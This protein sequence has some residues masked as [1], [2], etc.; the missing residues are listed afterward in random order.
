MLVVLILVGA[1]AV[2]AFAHE[3]RD[4]GDFEIEVGWQQEPIFVG[5]FNAAEVF[6]NVAGDAAD[7]SG[8][9]AMGDMG[10]DTGADEHDHAAAS[11]TGVV[12]AEETLQLEVSIGPA[13]RVFNLQ[14]VAEET[15]HY[16]VPLILTR[17]GDY[18]LRLFG[19]L[20]GVDIDETFTSADGQFNSVEPAGDVLFPDEAGASTSDLQA[21]I[22]DLTA[23]LD[24]LEGQ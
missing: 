19:T 23:R 24:A 6:I 4:V 3:S 14:A 1:L 2:P 15:G 5:M 13:S 11:D 12:G 17:P 8:D 20:N 10:S 16:V 21:R 18:T 22:D 9:A 7:M